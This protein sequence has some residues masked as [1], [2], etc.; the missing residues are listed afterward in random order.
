MGAPRAGLTQREID[1]LMLLEGGSSTREIA[2]RLGI[3]PSTTKDHLT[4]IYTKVGVTN[5]RELDTSSSNQHVD[6]TRLGLTQRQQEVT[7]FLLAGVTNQEIA[8]KLCLSHETV[9][10]HLRATYRR[11]GVRNRYEAIALLHR[12]AHLSATS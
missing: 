6:L 9:R 2:R 7:R 10:R 1:V 5:R 4:S 3:E 11:L 8:Q 12:S